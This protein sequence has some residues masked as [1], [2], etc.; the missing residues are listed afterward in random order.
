MEEQEALRGIFAYYAARPDRASQENIV[1][2]LREVQELS[3]IHISIAMYRCGHRAHLRGPDL[4]QMAFQRQ[5]KVFCQTAR[6]PCEIRAVPG[7]GGLGQ[8]LG[9][10]G[11]FGCLLY[12]SRCV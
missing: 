10:G 8:R 2:M 1:A 9:Q 3:L 11:P 7:R 5:E 4:R 6:G 12:T